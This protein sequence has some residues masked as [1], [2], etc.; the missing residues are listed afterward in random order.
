MP[1][2]PYHRCWSLLLWEPEPVPSDKVNPTIALPWRHCPRLR[3]VLRRYWKLFMMCRP[4][5]IGSSQRISAL[6]T[7]S[8]YSRFK[9]EERHR[10]HLFKIGF[11][12]ICSCQ[13]F[14]KYFQAFERAGGWI[15]K[16]EQII[17]RVLSGEDPA[18]QTIGKHLRT[19]S[20]RTSHSQLI[21]K[22]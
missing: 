6:L 3:T 11:C 9:R 22:S 8:P 7:F 13:S 17:S 1:L 19:T 2:L 5:Q 18:S 4:K 14:A 15:S 12:F 21:E 16:Q 10:R 20:H